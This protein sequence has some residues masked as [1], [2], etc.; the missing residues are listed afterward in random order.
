M[1]ERERERER[2]SLVSGSVLGEEALKWEFNSQTCHQ[3][4]STTW[5]CFLRILF[6][7][8]LFKESS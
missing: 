6:S 8:K 1:E 4:S 5:C 2:E 3:G 7:A